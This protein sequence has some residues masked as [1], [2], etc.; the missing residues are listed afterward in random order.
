MNKIMYSG[1]PTQILDQY[2]LPLY[3]QSR[4]IYGVDWSKAEWYEDIRF[5]GTYLTHH[6]S[7]T[8]SQTEV[9]KYKRQIQSDEQVSIYIPEERRWYLAR[10]MQRGAVLLFYHDF[11]SDFYGFH[12]VEHLYLSWWEDPSYILITQVIEADIVRRLARIH[13][14]NTILRDP[15]GEYSGTEIKLGKRA[16][17]VDGVPLR[18]LKYTIIRTYNIWRLNMTHNHHY[19]TLLPNPIGDHVVPID[20]LP[21]LLKYYHEDGYDAYLKIGRTFQN[22]NIVILQIEQTCDY[23][24][25]FSKTKEW[26]TRI[27]IPWPHESSP[28]DTFGRKPPPV[29][30]RDYRPITIGTLDDYIYRNFLHVPLL[31][32]KDTLDLMSTETLSHRY[33]LG[34]VGIVFPKRGYPYTFL[35]H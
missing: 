2:S 15:F 28:D 6:I 24:Y 20:Q 10:P 21:Q 31:T 19:H 14:P 22:P 27:T 33:R 12:R 3:I 17:K 5:D 4:P 9:K 35:V 32:H 23:K 8:R 30:W 13:P 34:Y 29:N 11:A 1:I 16:L 25:D 7:Y 18:D 26:H